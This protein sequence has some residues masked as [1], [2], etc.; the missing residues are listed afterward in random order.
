MGSQDFQ[1]GNGVGLYE[2]LQLLT[3]ASCF[4]Q[5]FVS[6]ISLFSVPVSKLVTLFEQDLVQEMALVYVFKIEQKNRVPKPGSPVFLILRGAGFK[7]MLT[8]RIRLPLLVLPICFLNRYLW[9]T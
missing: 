5:W 6:I 3:C 8:Q 7:I 9:S 4:I 2:H 1:L